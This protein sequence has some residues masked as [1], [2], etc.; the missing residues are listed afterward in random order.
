MSARN[1]IRSLRDRGDLAG[2]P[3]SSPRA[4]AFTLVL[5]VSFGAIAFLGATSGLPALLSA[6]EHKP[7]PVSFAK[8]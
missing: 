5:A 3:R 4:I 6:L 1:M 8:P 7:A 2:P